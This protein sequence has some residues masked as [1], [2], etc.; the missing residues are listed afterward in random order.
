MWSPTSTWHVGSVA[1]RMRCESQLLALPDRQ[2]LATCRGWGVEAMA[3]E[4]TT[5]DCTPAGGEG[6]RFA[7]S[8][9]SLLARC[10]LLLVGAAV[11]TSAHLALCVLPGKPSSGCTVLLV[12]DSY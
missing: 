6:P 5:L 11:G 8:G 9:C 12:L 10:W 4:C 7:A 1:C 2:T 3:T